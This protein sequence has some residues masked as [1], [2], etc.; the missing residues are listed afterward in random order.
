[1]SAPAATVRS[2]PVATATFSR[3]GLSPSGFSLRPAPARHPAVKGGCCAMGS[4]PAAAWLCAW[5]GRR[6]LPLTRIANPFPPAELEQSGCRAGSFPQGAPGGR[7]NPMAISFPR[8]LLRRLAC[9]S[10][11]CGSRPA[12]AGSGAR[13]HRCESPQP[14]L[15]ERQALVLCRTSRGECRFHS[16][17]RRAADSRPTS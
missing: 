2:G 10:R 14:A 13:L 8:V 5:Q 9:C 12:T 11:P 17:V 7:L 1:M 3:P 16:T 4:I 15:P 6:D